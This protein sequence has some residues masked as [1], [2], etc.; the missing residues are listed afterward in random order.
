MYSLKS[1]TW[2]LDYDECWITAFELNTDGYSM[3]TSHKMCHPG[4]GMACVFC[5]RF[6][7]KQLNSV[8][9]KK[10]SKLCVHR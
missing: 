2:L 5:N 6:K 4:G 7:V 1:E 8:I 10:P 9:N 3:V